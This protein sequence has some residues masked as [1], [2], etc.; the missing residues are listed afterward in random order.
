M[1]R[2]RANLAIAAL[3]APMFHPGQLARGQSPSVHPDAA[4]WRF[5]HPNA[6]ALVSINWQ[7]IRQS[8]EGAMIRDKLLNT[9]P[10]AAIPGLELLDTIDRVVLSLSGDETPTDTDVEAAP[11]PLLVALRGHFDAARLRQLFKRLGGKAQAYNSFQVYRPQGKDA[12]NLAYVLFDAGTILFGDAP[13]LFAALE[14]NRFAP[15][16]PE[17]GSI[18]A[19]AAEMDASY[20]LSWVMN[21][22]GMLS[23]HQLADL[24][25]GDEW[26]QDAQAFEVGVNLHS[27]MTAD[28]TVRFASEA[29]A[30]GVVAELTRLTDV[31]LQE[32]VLQDKVSKD[33]VS[34]DRKADLQ[35]QDIVRKLK[36]SSDGSA[37]KISLRLTSRELEA[38][39]EAFAASGGDFAP[40]ASA[41]PATAPEAVPAPAPSKPGVIRIE[42]LDEGPREIPYPDP[43]Q[44]H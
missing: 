21:A 41:S 15:P 3:L 33:R 12:K 44:P 18:I 9:F 6:K 10:I 43:N 16:A 13:S 23:S 38:S 36:F 4:L 7:R 14:R 11:T 22:D 2:L 25:R 1:P 31:V 37:A 8:S 5:V 24:F 40:V 34:K 30:K 17:P 29:A 39:V 27:G 28:V 32:K 19:R 42:G 26:A 20:E 35:M